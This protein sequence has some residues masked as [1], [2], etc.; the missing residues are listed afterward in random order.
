MR[1][2]INNGRFG[3]VTGS[4]GWIPSDELT[5]RIWL[6]SIETEWKTGISQDYLTIDQFGVNNWTDLS[7]SSRDM[8]QGNNSYK[9]SISSLNSKRTVMFN[10]DYLQETVGNSS[11]QPNTII[12]ISD[13][14]AGILTKTNN[15]TNWN[16]ID[17]SGGFYRVRTNN[18][19]IASSYAPDGNYHIF[20]AQINGA[21]TFLRIDGTQVAS[22]NVGTKPNFNNQVLGDGSGGFIGAIGE[23]IF[24]SGT[25]TTALIEKAEGYLS[26][27]WGVQSQLPIGHTYKTNYPLPPV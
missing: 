15:G 11:G 22:G 10:G 3:G 19:A 23:Y 20:I 24:I 4:G 8:I 2:V 6:D 13:F 25:L 26:H 21:S 14:S 5:M 16:G 27:K 18:T 7:G 12:A 17:V 1:N 9:P